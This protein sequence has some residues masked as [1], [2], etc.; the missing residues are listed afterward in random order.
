MIRKVITPLTGGGDST[1]PISGT[2]GIVRMRDE[3]NLVNGL[4]ELY[5]DL[6]SRGLHGTMVELGS[7][8][9]ESTIIAADYFDSVVA[10]DPWELGYSY[11]LAESEYRDQGLEVHKL[12]LDRIR[13]RNNIRAL[14][15]FGVEA[16]RYF[17]PA[18]LD[19]VYIDAWHR[20]KS[21]K[22]DIITWLPKLKPG[23]AIGGHDYDPAWPGV[24]QAVNEL[25]G[26]EG[27]KLFQDTS[28]L[29]YNDRAHAGPT[30]AVL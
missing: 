8:A 4:R 15:M 6:R 23:G 10:V 20:Y 29:A 12:F 27:L 30:E 11:T 9:G 3:P 21:V 13:P 14:C 28:W 7:Y 25:I 5:A 22:E 26:V 18:S 19:F 17:A 1:I 2:S 24:A 16:A